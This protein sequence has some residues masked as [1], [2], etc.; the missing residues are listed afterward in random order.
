VRVSFRLPPLNCAN[1]GREIEMDSEDAIEREF[2][3]RQLSYI[4]AIER[5]QAI[6]LEPIVAER[7]V[8]EWEDRD[9]NAAGAVARK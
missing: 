4:D 1:N 3:A 9:E 2:K 6:G 8:C 7:R 5:L